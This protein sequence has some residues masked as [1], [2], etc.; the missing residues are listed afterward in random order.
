M[1]APRAIAKALTLAFGMKE[2]SL[3]TMI[4]INHDSLAERRA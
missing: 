3:T 1:A 4:E 2:N